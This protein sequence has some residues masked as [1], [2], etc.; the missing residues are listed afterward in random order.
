MNKQDIPGE[1]EQRKSEQITPGRGAP[2]APLPPQR[3]AAGSGPGKGAPAVFLS[4]PARI[5]QPAAAGAGGTAAGITWAPPARLPFEHNP[6][7]TA[8]LPGT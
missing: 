3:R 5:P 4:L 7:S 2:P 1:N 6:P 8:V